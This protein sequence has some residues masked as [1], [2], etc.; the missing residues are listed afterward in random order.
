MPTPAMAQGTPDSFA[1]MENPQHPFSDS[2]NKV[3]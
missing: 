3:E 2:N 1:S